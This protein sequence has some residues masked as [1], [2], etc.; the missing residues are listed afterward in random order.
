MRAFTKS[1]TTSFVLNE[2]P[3][4][5]K[6]FFSSA[7]ATQHRGRAPLALAK[8][9]PPPPFGAWVRSRGNAFPLSFA[10]FLSAFPSISFLRSLLLSYLGWFSL[11]VLLCFGL[12]SLFQ[13]NSYSNLPLKKVQ[14]SLTKPTGNESIIFICISCSAGRSM[15]TTFCRLPASVYFL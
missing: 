6:K 12:I 10:R 5:V 7:L 3:Y 9:S 15:H 2:Q 1:N 4:K 11:L 8:P 13:G 14:G